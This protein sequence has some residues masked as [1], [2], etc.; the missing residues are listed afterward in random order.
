[1]RNEIV[2]LIAASLCLH[3]DDVAGKFTIYMGGKPVAAESYALSKADGKI[4][5]TGSGKADLGIIKVN[6]EKFNIVTDEQFQPVSVDA[7]ATMGKVRMQ[8]AITFAEGKAKNQ[9]DTGQGPQAKDDA[10]HPDTLVVNSNLPLYAWSILALRAK[11]DSSDPQTF[12]AYIIGQTEV[13][14]TVVSKGKEAVEFAGGT[15]ELNHLSVSFPVSPT[16]PP[17]AVEFW[18]N[19]AR[20]IIKAAVPSQNVEAYQDGFER[21]APPPPPPAPAT[22][23]VKPPVN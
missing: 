6:I 13:P 17:T 19:D 21:K 8:D 1:M 16:A 9:M 12:H 4:Q 7:D 3:A 11:L 2:L 20:K 5:L 22:P 14:V 15:T 10:V 23:E 18:V